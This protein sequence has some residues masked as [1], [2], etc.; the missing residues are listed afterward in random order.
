LWPLSDLSSLNRELTIVK[1]ASIT[2][3]AAFNAVI[4]AK[5]KG[6]EAFAFIASW[7]C[8]AV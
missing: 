1:R 2:K 4:A 7:I 8:V 5:N 6:R 3:L